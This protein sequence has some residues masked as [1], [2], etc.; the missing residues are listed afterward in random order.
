[1]V[2]MV[3]TM[4]TMELDRKIEAEAAIGS[5]AQQRVVCHCKASNEMSNEIDEGC[6]RHRLK[7][8][9]EIRDTHYRS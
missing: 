2:T 3:T 1:M 4:A 5:A 8:D 7:L 9:K 6:T